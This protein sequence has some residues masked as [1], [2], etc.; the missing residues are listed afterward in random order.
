MRRVEILHRDYAG[1]LTD[2]YGDP[3]TPLE[4]TEHIPEA[5]VAPTSTQDMSDA[6]R[7]GTEEALDVYLPYDVSVAPHDV[8]K[9]DGRSYS[10]R[11]VPS[12]WDGLSGWQAGQVVHVYR[13]LG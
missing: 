1:G 8:V 2:V 4:S 7:N 6:A 5:M 9:V 11:G 13:S 3:T 10:I 12:L